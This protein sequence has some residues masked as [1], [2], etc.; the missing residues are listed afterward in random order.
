M[1]KFV[2]QNSPARSALLRLDIITRMKTFAQQPYTGMFT[3]ELRSHNNHNHC[4]HQLHYFGSGTIIIIIHKAVT[5]ILTH[6]L[7]VVFT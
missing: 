3:F 5:I 4:F 6:H 2:A 7:H 1:K